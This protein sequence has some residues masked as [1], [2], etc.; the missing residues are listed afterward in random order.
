MG[1]SLRHAEAIAATGATE[2][3]AL[4]TLVVK[5]RGAVLYLNTAEPAGDATS[6]GSPARRR[7]SLSAP[8]VATGPMADVIKSNRRGV[9]S[10]GTPGSRGIR[11]QARRAC[12]C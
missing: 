9:R 4:G 7:T 2:I 3:A 5:V 12:P 8:V 6:A 10:T 1:P 11:R